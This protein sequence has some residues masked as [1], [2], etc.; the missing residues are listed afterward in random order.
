MV[1]PG[2]RQ[3]ASSGLSANAISRIRCDPAVALSLAGTKR[4]MISSYPTQAFLIERDCA[5]Y[6]ETPQ[7]SDAMMGRAMS[8]P[9]REPR[10]RQEH[11]LLAKV[12]LGKRHSVG[13]PKMP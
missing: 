1:E 12:G 8:R 5:R 4:R 3:A 13:E 2:G 11:E 7:L 6:I 9:R 10:N